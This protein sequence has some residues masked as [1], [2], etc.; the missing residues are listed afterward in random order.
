M[1]VADTGRGGVMEIFKIKELVKQMCNNFGIEEKFMQALITTESD[2]NQWCVR[3]EPSYK[4]IVEGPD[5]GGIKTTPITESE[6]QKYSYGLCQIMGNWY[7]DMGFR[8][9]CTELLD[10]RLN[11]LIATK[12]IKKH[13]LDGIESVDELY[14]VYNAGS[15][16][17]KE[18]G[19]FCNQ[20]NVDNFLKNY[21]KIGVSC[22]E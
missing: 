4:W 13:M 14:S 1:T 17:L 18:D 2:W 21:N 8:G 19:T 5:T 9:F 16:R 3:Y 22:S 6:M 7:Y 11:I 20:K 12:I 10:P 15:L